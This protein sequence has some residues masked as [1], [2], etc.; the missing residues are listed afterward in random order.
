MRP[1]NNRKALVNSNRLL[2]V[3]EQFRQI[4]KTDSYDSRTTIKYTAHMY[5]IPNIMGG[6]I[7]SNQ[8]KTAESVLLTARVLISTFIPTE[9]FLNMY[10]I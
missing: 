7:C 8:N 10:D 9:E 1:K 5:M 3:Y 4:S 2:K 6:F